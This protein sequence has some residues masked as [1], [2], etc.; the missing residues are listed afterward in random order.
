[1][2]SKSGAEEAPHEPV[3]NS[4][5]VVASEPVVINEPVVV[6]L[7]RRKRRARSTRGLGP[8]E[9][10]QRGLA[11]ASLRVA[12]AVAAGMETYL[13]ERDKSASRKRDGALRD[14]HLNVADAVG[15]ILRESKDVPRELARGIDTRETRRAIRRSVR[16]AA[17]VN[18]ALL[19]LR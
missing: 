16:T 17:R 9:G 5:P 10:A 4:E 18:R 11:R 12:R 2:A 7:E 19:G 3:V 13:D 8:V 1:M 6:N 14:L 15:T